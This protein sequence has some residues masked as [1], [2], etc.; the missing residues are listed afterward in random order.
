MSDFHIRS[1]MHE[2]K[3]ANL[4][5]QKALNDFISE[6]RRMADLILNEIWS[7]GY[8]WIVNNKEYVFSINT[9]KLDTPS[10]IDYKLF[11]HDTFLTARA[12]SSLCTQLCGMIGASC[13][14]QRK[15][16]YQYNKMKDSGIPKIKLQKLIKKIKCNIPQKP[17]ISTINME[18]S[19]KCIDWQESNGLYFGFLRIK[20]FSKIHGHI[21]IPIIDHKHCKKMKEKGMLMNSFLISEKRIFLRWKIEKSIKSTGCAIGIDQGKKDLITCSSGFVSPT[22]CPHGHTLSSILDSLARKKKGSKSF[23]QTQDHRKNF[24]N[25]SINQ[26]NVTDINEIKL[27]EIINI[28]YKNRTNR[29]MSHWTNTLI[30]DKISS[31][32][33]DNGV[34]FTMQSSTYRSQRCNNCSLVRKANR[35]GK[36]YFCNHCGYKNDADLNASLNLL[37]DLPEIPYNLRKLGKNRGNGFFWKDDGFFDYSTGVSLSPHP[38]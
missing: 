8:T 13:E 15:R 30:R 3:Y 9:N 35:K 11:N 34:R 10:Y 17:D 27:E 37:I 25:W 32:C 1:S 26:L 20:S 7:N 19:S 5:K 12:L 18:L 6:Y 28:G 33:E 2:T 24:I 16:I 14:K 22:A 21:K 29:V 23:K 38:I 4:Q 31:Y 36:I